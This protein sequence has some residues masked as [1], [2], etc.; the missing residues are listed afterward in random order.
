MNWN[1]KSTAS[2]RATQRRESKVEFET[3]EPRQL[4]CTF[5][6]AV[7]TANALGQ[8]GTDNV[9]IQFQGHEEAGFV[10]GGN[11]ILVTSEGDAPDL[12]PG[13]G[14]CA[15]SSGNS[16]T[17]DR[18]TVNSPLPQVLFGTTIDATPRPE[19]AFNN[20]FPVQPQVTLR[21]GVTNGSAISGLVVSGNFARVSGLEVTGF[22][23]GVIVAGTQNEVVGNALVN[24]RFNGLW[25]TGNNNDIGY[26]FDGSSQQRKGNLLS[27]N[28]HGIFIS[29]SANLNLVE[30]NF[31]GTNQ[32]GTAADANRHSGVVITADLGRQTIQNNVI[33]G[34][35]RFGILSFADSGVDIRNNEIGTNR[36]GTNA[37]ANRLDGVVLNGNG[38]GGS[39]VANNVISGNLRD[40]IVNREGGTL[41]NNNRIGV[42]QAG[43]VA[44]GNRFGI[45]AQTGSGGIDITNNTISGNSLAGVYVF[46]NEGFGETVITG[47][48]IGTNSSG[49]VAIPNDQ[50]VLLNREANAVR[51]GSVA[52]AAVPAERN[53]ISGNTRNGISVVGGTASGT[54][55]VGQVTIGN[56]LIGVGQRAGSNEFV[57]IGNG[58]VGIFVSDGGTTISRNQIANN[59]NA[60]ISIVSSSGATDNQADEN[61]ITGNLIGVMGNFLSPNSFIPAGNQTGIFLSNSDDNIIG[62][63]TFQL[64]GGNF[65]QHNTGTGV[66]MVSSDGN[67]LTDNRIQFN[68][69]HGIFTTNGNGNTIGGAD[70]LAVAGIGNIIT[71]NGF[72]GV[73]VNN[74]DGNEIH[75]NSI[76]NN[77][78]LGINLQ[79]VNGNNNQKAPTVDEILQSNTQLVRGN[80]Q[81]VLPNTLYVIEIF[82]STNSSQ[83][84]EGTVFQGRQAI[85]TNASGNL[86]FSIPVESQI[87]NGQF[88][89]A[90]ATMEGPTSAFATNGDTSQFS[91]PFRVLS[92][93]Q[94]IAGSDVALLSDQQL[95][96]PDNQDSKTSKSNSDPIDLDT[97]IEPATRAVG[98]GDVVQQPFVAQ[99]FDRISNTATSTTAE[100]GERWIE[101]IDQVINQVDE[102]DWVGDLAKAHQVARN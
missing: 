47:N 93:R 100:N 54:F 22:D 83:G 2:K 71:N 21:N 44:I 80:L 62:S 16:F 15:S 51:I 82:S 75:R 86:D 65:I 81:A 64:F 23:H 20:N 19:D 8:Q 39:I 63:P 35:T 53:I 49:D 18:I 74:G 56:N 72:S 98:L 40:G 45:N 34:N 12:N 70:G 11:Q 17:V 99:A 31:I 57:A 42:N 101:L 79:G 52:N 38:N 3:L 77:G 84:I 66:S 36:L 29:G 68:Q 10:A 32:N 97:K 92:G 7:Q 73:H 94:A 96:E 27:N 13:D 25:I 6:A 43:N 4:L 78:G 91:T 1:F 76:A 46:R 58:A 28:N 50:G 9:Q 41:I 24:N 26:Y 90:T 89:T 30:N 14:V 95:R 102:T 69:G 59:G 87:F 67:W 88:I 55:G 85:T 60:G 33:S 5:R 48:R 37:V 61:V